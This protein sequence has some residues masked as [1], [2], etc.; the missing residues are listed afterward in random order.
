[1][2]YKCG[3]MKFNGENG[4]IRYLKT[5]SMKERKSGRMVDQSI[6]G[7]RTIVTEYSGRMLTQEGDK[8]IA[9]SGLAQKI[10]ES[11]SFQ[12]EGAALYL[13]GL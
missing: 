7:W 5:S 8:L 9:I 11:I 12:D 6:D 2:L 1:M 10:M 13:G 3:H 4:T